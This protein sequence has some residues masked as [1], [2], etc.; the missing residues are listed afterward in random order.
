MSGAPG[1]FRE[2][3]ERRAPLWQ[4]FRAVAWSFFGIRRS[5]G[6]QHDAQ[7]LNPVHLIVAGLISAALF[8]G[9][10]VLIVNWVASR[11]PGG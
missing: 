7:K 4:S 1:E 8:V 3:L 11:G 6:L 10:L 5:T 2:V 9:V